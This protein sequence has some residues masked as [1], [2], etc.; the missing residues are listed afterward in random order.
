MRALIAW[1]FMLAFVLMVVPMSF[2][3]RWCRP[4]FVVLLVIYWSLFSPQY[5]GLSMAWCVGLFQD[6]LESTLLGFNALGILLIAYICHLV[7]QR[8][9]HY[10][11]WHQA[12]WI[13][14]LVG[15]FQLFSNWLTGFM[16]PMLNSPAFLLPAL[17]SSFLWPLLVVVMRYLQLKF[18]LHQ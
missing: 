3:W 4:E 5:F 16:G 12:L 9:R 6:L 15:V 17:I 7:S 1:S 2:Q 11:L 8:M 10:V 14:I 13:F 18:R